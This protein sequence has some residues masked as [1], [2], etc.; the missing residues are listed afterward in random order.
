MIYINSVSVSPRRACAAAL[1]SGLMALALWPAPASAE[2]LEEALANVYRTNPEL[3]A[4]RRELGAVNESVPQ[5]LANWRPEVSLRGS[6]GRR[7]I[8]QRSEFADPVTGFDETRSVSGTTTPL[9]GFLEMRQPLYRGGR[10]VAGVDRAENE[11]LAQRARL[12]NT[13]QDVF[14]R[15]TTAYM[16]VWRDEALLRLNES[17]VEVLRQQL[18]ATQD[19]F[20]V[21]EVTRTDVAQAESFLARA[22]ADRIVAAGNLETSRAVYLDVVGHPPVDVQPPELPEILPENRDSAISQAR[23]DN[24]GLVAAQFVESA[25]SEEVRQVTGELLPEASL[26]GRVGR[27]EDTTTPDTRSDSAEILAELVI[28]LYQQGFV[29]SRVRQFK[30]IAS[31]R[32]QE[33]AATGRRVEQEAVAAW[34]DLEAAQARIVALDE[35]VRAAEIA[36]EGVREEHQVGERTVLDILEAQQELLDA[37]VELVI[38][39]RDE[40]VA[41]HNV[42]ATVGRLRARTLELPVEFFDVEG[43]YRAVRDRIWGWELPGEYDGQE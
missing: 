29:S 16:D 2:P 13:E 34:E 10:T 6:V 21:G 17:N 27:Q 35:Q 36:L 22:I 23:V 4:A 11:V 19:R 26:V 31:Q 37:E 40:I 8:D 1:L 39:R 20:E 41:S 30:Q 12:A 28:P 18:E 24:P 25:A 15:T 38:A 32:R 7:Y 42:L 5:E 3:E 43:E 33:L 9:S 14:L